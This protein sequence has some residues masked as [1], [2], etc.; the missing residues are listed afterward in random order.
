MAP[1]LNLVFILALGWPTFRYVPDA[2]SDGRA[3]VRVQL[4]DTP[5][6]IIDV[7]FCSDSGT[8][9]SVYYRPELC[10]TWTECLDYNMPP[11]CEGQQFVYEE[12]STTVP[13]SGKRFFNFLYYI[14]GSISAF[15]DGVF[16]TGVRFGPF[17]GYEPVD[18]LVASVYWLGGL[19]LGHIIR[20]LIIDRIFPVNL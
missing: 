5:S 1:T 18:Q 2:N 3:D 14:P 4:L 9:K 12:G 13:A 19:F 11:G 16:G 15:I 10:P 20:T 6:A 17:I 8:A 7:V